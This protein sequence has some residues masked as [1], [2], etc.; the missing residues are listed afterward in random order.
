[1]FASSLASFAGAK[2]LGT[3]A[4]RRGDGVTR[5]VQEL[6]DDRPLL[7]A[8]RFHPLG[9]G[10]NAAGAAEVAD[11]GGLERLLVGRGGDFRQARRRAIVPARETSRNECSTFN[12]NVQLD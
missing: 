9:P 10:R 3:F 6:A 7:L 2:T 5:F 4:D 11:A 12:V 1:M 8:E